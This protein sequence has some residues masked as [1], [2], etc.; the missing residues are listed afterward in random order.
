MLLA[1]QPVAVRDGNRL[2]A[3]VDPELGEDVLNVGRDRLRADKEFLCDL[4]LCETV[5]E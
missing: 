5:G 4:R 1:Q 3:A 2:R